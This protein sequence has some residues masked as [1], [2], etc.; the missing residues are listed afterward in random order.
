VKYSAEENSGYGENERE[1]EE[2]AIWLSFNA[3]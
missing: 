1:N 2:K 3:S